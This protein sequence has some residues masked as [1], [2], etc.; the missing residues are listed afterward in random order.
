MRES[1]PPV[2]V[3]DT[4]QQAPKGG[5]E[6]QDTRGSKKVVDNLRKEN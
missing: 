6:Y 2:V 5:P 1:A 4:H 3:N